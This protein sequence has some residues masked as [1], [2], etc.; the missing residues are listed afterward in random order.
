MKKIIFVLIFIN[1]SLCAFA[2]STGFSLTNTFGGMEGET[3]GEDFLQLAK[4]SQNSNFVNTTELLISDRISAKYKSSFID[5]RFRIDIFSS[6]MTA[7]S[8]ISTLNSE[9]KGFVGFTPADYITFYAGNNFFSKFGLD[10]AYFAA[11]DDTPNYGKILKS[12]MGFYSKVNLGDNA[13]LKLGFGVDGDFLFNGNTFKLYSGAQFKLKNVIC[14]GGTYQ[15]NS[16]KK[17]KAGGFVSL[18][19]DKRLVANFGYTYNNTDDDFLSAKTLHSLQASIGYNFTELDLPLYFY[20]DV[21]SGLNNQYL[22]DGAVKT[23]DGNYIPVLFASKIGYDF[24]Q[25][26]NAELFVKYTGVINLSNSAVLTVF[27]S[28]TY[29]VLDD[30]DTLIFGVKLISDASVSNGINRIAI[31]L[32]W[33]HVF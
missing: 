4:T 33:K 19:F 2:K 32:S 6:A 27:P 3:G 25:E 15:N 8:I 31:P 29:R 14:V 13:N 26:F 16:F 5:S 20:V 11:L 10:G 24:T 12:G 22:K 7:K 1:F 9:F 21:I 18:D 23:Y 28:V 17:T 30:K